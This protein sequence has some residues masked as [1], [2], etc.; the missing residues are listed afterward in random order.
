MIVSDICCEFLSTMA[1]VMS[2]REK[3][4]IRFE[5]GTLGTRGQG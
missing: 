4:L 3:D 2:Y 1:I 5:P